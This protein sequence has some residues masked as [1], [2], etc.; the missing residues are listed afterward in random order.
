[1]MTKIGRNGAYFCDSGEKYKESHGN[2]SESTG[3]GQKTRKFLPPVEVSTGSLFGD[4]QRYVV[5]NSGTHPKG[6]PGKYKIIFTLS[7][8][9]IVLL[10]PNVVNFDP[11][12]DGDSYIHLP[13]DPTSPGT[14]QRMQ[15]S[16]STPEGMF[17]F[18]GYPNKSGALGR[19]VCEIEALNFAD[20]EKKT[21]RALASFLSSWSTQLDIP[22]DIIRVHITE[23]STESVQVDFVVPY[24]TIPFVLKPEEGL[25]V[26]FRGYASLY[27]EALDSSSLIYRFLCFFKIIEAIKTRRKRLGQEARSK[28]NILKRPIEV[29]PSDESHFIPWLNGIFHPK[30]NW[31]KLDLD[32]IFLNEIRGKKFNWIIEKFLNPLRVDI[33]HAIFSETGELGLSADE[34]LHSDRVK[35]FLP[36]TK[37]ITRWM[38]KNEFRYNFLNFVRDDGSIFNQSRK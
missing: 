16:G 20:A 3:T 10:A 31:D 22:I 13:N 17:V 12:M 34:L 19:F 6:S 8:P 7:K 38:L 2:P 23:L 1:M 27:R 30:R 18:T 24:P 36:V 37:C 5:T 35:R 25:D 9:W 4:P 21:F 28:G 15:I 26:E 33:A 11:D 14:F 29:V 32:L